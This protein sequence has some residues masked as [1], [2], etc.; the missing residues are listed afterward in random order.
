MQTHKANNFTP[1]APSRA[2]FGAALLLALLVFMPAGPSNAAEYRA[3][4]LD[5]FH[6]G[7]R[8]QSQ[9]DALLGVPGTTARG[10]IRDVNCNAVFIQVRKR[11]DVC[12]PSGV[13][14]PY[15]SGLSPAN[16]DALAALI[17]AAH[18][19]TGGKKRIEVHCWSVAFKTA[20]GLVYQQHT[21]TP[22]GSLTTFDNYWPTRLSSTT[23]AE[24]SDG[25]FDPGHPK[26]LEYLVNTHMDLVNFQTT[27]GP[28]GT[29]GHIDGIHYD[30]I[31]FEA[32]TEGF[33]PTSVARYNAR[34]GLS[35]DPASSSEQFK[36]WRRDQCTAFVRQMYARIQKS[37]PS[38]KQSCAGVT[39]NPSPTASTRAAFQATRPYYDVYSDWDSWIQEGI[40]DM[41]V[42][43]TYYDW[44]GSY[45]ADFTR[46]MNWEKD[47]HGT[48]LMVIGPGI[49]MN[50]LANAIY[51]LQMIRDPSPS[52][53]YA[54]GFCGYSYAVPYVSGSWAGFTNSLVTTI[55]PTWDDVPE[56]P[57]KTSPTKAHIMGTVTIYGTGAWA[58]G[59][60]VSLTGPVSRV[61]T[62][63]GT[64]FYAFI[65]LPV[66]TYNVTA[67][68]AGH[69]SASGSVT[70]AVGQVTGNMYE[71]NLVLGGNVPP[72]I[73][74]QPLSQSVNQ[75]ANATFTVSASGSTP[76][77]YQWRLDGANIAGATASSY[78]RSN[79]QPAD[80]GSY[81]VVVTNL[82]GT[83]TSANA[84]LT[85]LVPP[86]ITTQPLSQ[87]VTQGLNATFTVAASGTTPF[88]YQ[89]RFNGTPIGGA[90]ASSYTRSNVQP[91]DAGSYSVV[92]TN[93]AGTAT[94]ANAVLT[95][96]VPP[97][98]PVIVTQPQGQTV[99]LGGTASFN[100]VA[101]GSAPLSYQWRFN[102]ADIGGA[103]ASSYTR[104]NLQA[105]DAGDY[106]V[107][108]TNLY[109]SE[110]SANATLIVDTDIPLPVITAQPQ[111]QTVIAGQS[112]T[113]TVT[114]TNKAPMSYQWRF[115]GT[116]IAGATGTAYTVANAQTGD[117]GSYSVV[118]ANIIGSTTSADAVLT[119]HFSLTASA[120]PG[121]TVSKSP[122]QAS[123]A[124][125]DV[126]TLTAT[127]D[128]GSE[129]LGWSGDATG[130]NNPLLVTMTAN[131][132]ITASF[133]GND[134]LDIILDN[135]NAAVTFVGEWQAGTAS[136]DKYGDDYRFAST[137]AGGQSNVIYRPYICAAGYYDV[138]IWYPAGLN[139]ATNAPWSVV[140]DGGSV[141]VPVNQ[142]VN[143]GTWVSL[144]TALPFA[145]GTSGYVQVSND[146]GY[147][148]T[149]I[150]VMADAVRFV[151]VTNITLTATAAGGGAVYKYPDQAGYEP[152]TA[153]SLIAA[154]VL[155]WNFSGWSGGASGTANPLTVT[156]FTNTSITGNF[157]SSVPNLIVDDSDTGGATFTGSWSQRTASSDYG[158]GYRRATTVTGTATAT[159][160]FRPT[161]ATA[162][163]YDV[164]VWYPSASSA[165]TAAPFLVSYDGGS[166]N[167]NVNQTTGTGSW[168]LIASAMPFA[169]GTSGYVRLS[170]NTT[171]SGQRVFADA[172]R[173]VYSANQDSPP[174]II[175]QPQSQTVDA[176]AT[177]TFSALAA[178]T[179]PLS[180]QWRFNGADIAGA[181][182]S[183][184]TRSNLQSGDEG[185]YSVVVNNAVG[186]ITSSSAVLTVIGGPVNVAPTIT[187]QPQ[188]QNVNQGGDATFTVSATGTPAPSYQWRFNS[189]DIPG[190][191]ASSYTR[192]N[193]QPADAGSYS[194]VVTNLAGSVTS[195]DA[196]LTVNV[197]PVITAQPQDQNVNQG[198]DAVFSVVATGTPAPSYQWRKN[199]TPIGGATDSSYT[200]ANAQP[201][202]AG[203]Y[204]VEVSN[205]AGT[206][207]SADAMLTVNVAPVIT[208]QPQDQNVNQGS[209]AVFSVVATG[210][211]APSYQW[212]KDGTPI[213]GATDSSYTVANAQPGDAGSYSVEVSNVAGTVT[214]ADAALTVNVAPVITT[215]PQ[216]Q[217][218]NQ[219]SNAVFSVVATG[220]PAPS[221]QWRKNGTP[222]PGATDSGYTVANAQPGDEG[223]YSV[224]VSNV[225]GTVTSADAALTVNVAPV[226]TAQP[227]DQNVNQTSN[228]VFSVV[229]T[230][231]PAPSYQWR[232]NGTPIPGAT[233]SSYTVANAQP[234]DEGSYSVEVSNVAGTVTSADAA[235]T[236][237]VAPVITAQP[238]D[239]NVNQTS[240]AVFSVVATGTPAPSYQWRK[241]GTPIPG[242][243]DSSYTVANAQPGDEG[244][245]SVEVSNVAGTVTSAD[246]AL[247]VNV[248]PVITAQ[249]Q[250]QNVNQTSNAVF[251]VVATGTPAPSY[252]WR[253]NGTPIPGATDSGYTV[254]NAQPGDEGS[255]SVEVSNVAG[256]VTSADA[257]LTVNVAPVITAQPQDQNVN[258]G[259]DAVFSVVATGTPAPSYQWRKDGT[260]IPGATDSSYTVANAQPGDEGSYSVEVSNVAGT[261]TSADAM[262]TVNVAPV[263]TAQPQD[264]NVNEGS[265]AVFSV[266]AT[267]TPAPSYQW[268]KNGTPIPGA[269]DSSYTVANA[270]PGD[271]G[272]YSVEVSNVAGTVT[273]ADA[274]L[275]VSELTAPRIDLIGLLAGGQVQLQ[276][277]G[278]PGHYAVEATADLRETVIWTELTNYTTT[279]TSFQFV[280]PETGLTQRFY[281]VRL[282]P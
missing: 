160:T 211:P 146:T 185:S 95:V 8:D 230:G 196:V 53:N 157:V 171:V 109:G 133:G 58:D 222:I 168:Q 69:P 111:S 235:L 254:A 35:G 54:D 81:S 73:T 18:D 98:P 21:N 51:E 217:N 219:T 281:R 118:I 265:D 37:K 184:Y 247:T 65:D 112:A 258:E 2:W 11:A 182:A 108:V 32:N 201:G 80:A 260:P 166:L 24:N 46:W 207:T 275:T 187:A 148:A 179:A 59:A 86:T 30:Y 44:A 240:N 253:K 91:G 224:E 20:K 4:W 85:V 94:S 194:V 13:G 100:V 90:T 189:M 161:I 93:L 104:A 149:N 241:D 72:S 124:P 245:Y 28:D 10:Q 82:A 175:A 132:T 140:Y 3:F 250:D 226:I 136:A 239:Q 48:R 193:V 280:D 274:V 154:P 215:Q 152:N 1:H 142:Q 208:A 180:Y 156:V 173:W 76:L 14:E 139:R 269:T 87:T 121:G 205:V 117:A 66:G 122:D 128:V 243:T 186:S 210:A 55:T 78:T 170:N 270:Q 77:S 237:N 225:A 181:T 198:N 188:D 92:V 259:S 273:S 123:Y 172:V 22:T 220:T 27:A 105:G 144:G 268:R 99:L 57:W 221:Y 23:G 102:G 70:V 271:A 96:V 29:D 233:D 261:V 257:A 83:A 130:T 197:A 282:M 101:T 163:R 141:N 199:G 60:T 75:G 134:C 61:Q 263:I 9:V 174:V 195:V 6:S 252:Q 164:Y 56:M 17:K 178:G 88:S 68:L 127:A 137:A 150:V 248:A 238:Q 158:S 131:M 153:V 110:L 126:V 79:V 114:A 34:Y 38:V 278:A 120:T 40:L 169:A 39:W 107:L 49:Y 234:G 113:F 190:A 176:G 232:K 159:A 145:Q 264:Q 16:F 26:C 74:S 255:Y 106:S 177:A 191:T 89:W 214:S 50:S 192:N 246:A 202:D 33:N 236:V 200:V 165:S 229:A 116:P 218:V 31:R 212:R 223:S 63:D 277:S 84:V 43:M 151:R 62:N 125:N 228:A 64:G 135:T 71:V 19:T 147:T 279:G 97:D 183:A 206:V 251:S 167:V 231:T 143:G 267:G 203:S 129:F 272:S 115:N 5:A 25:A 256:T 52:G 242:A 249:P 45:P 7:F 47:R 209:N 276:V 12:Y 262:L 155:G 36:Q 216:D 103:T 119:V 42:P 227:Q 15:M 67:S 266:V 162:G 244:S 41:A 204:S 138:F 213:P